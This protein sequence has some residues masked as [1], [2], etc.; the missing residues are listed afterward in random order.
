MKRDD[1]QQLGSAPTT[2][3]PEGTRVQPDTPVNVAAGSTLDMPA[4]E[5]GEVARR[6]VASRGPARSIGRFV[7]R[8]RLGEGGMGVVLA[9]H[10]PELDRHVAIKLLRDGRRS[11]RD[12][13][14]LLR[15][16]QAMA[17]LAHP[18]VV[19]VYEVGSDRGRL[20]IA[21]ELVEGVTLATWLQAAPRRGARSSTMFVQAGA[22]SRPRTAPA[23]C[24]AT[25]SPTTCSSTQRPRARRR[26]RPRAPRSRAATPS[27][28]LG[29]SLTQAPAR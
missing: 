9:A 11:P 6:R 17:R 23:S 22:G 1:D 13:A 3:A 21:M 20:F 10:D 29:A 28:E 19:A 4:A 14:R 26:L 16:A 15:E 12:R 5:R 25:S 18:N 24:I 7:V 8:E 2:P 27:P